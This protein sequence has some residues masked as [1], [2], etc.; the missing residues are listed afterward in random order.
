[1]KNTLLA[2][3]ALSLLCISAIWAS[4]KVTVNTNSEAK[5]TM[6]EEKQV[7]IVFELTPDTAQNIIDNNPLLVVDFYAEWCG[8]C[9]TLKP[10]FEEVA[11][12]SSPKHLFAKVNIDKLPAIATKYSVTTIPTIVIFS[13][14][15]VIGKVTGLVSKETLLEKIETATKGPKDLSKL[16]KEELNEKLWQ[17]VY[18]MEGV[19]EVKRFIDAGANVNFEKNG[20]TPLLMVMMNCGMRGVD[21]APYLKLLLDAGAQTQITD[22]AGVV[23]ELSDAATQ[24]GDNMRTMAQ[25]YDK[26]ADQI[27]EHKQK[28]TKKCDG[29]TCQL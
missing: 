2:V 11:K 21:A 10:V 1:M 27:K 24:M 12:E 19:D 8:P 28:S 22:P 3:S 17:A 5:P 25:N 23:R 15:K 29:N 18:T 13:N 9:K 26:M 6:T 4:K 16:S 14:G 7:D 20:A